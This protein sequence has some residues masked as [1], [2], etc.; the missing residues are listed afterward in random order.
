M[1]HFASSIY[2]E[3]SGYTRLISQPTLLKYTCSDNLHCA[4]FTTIY[5]MHISGEHLSGVSANNYIQDS[6][7][8]DIAANHFEHTYV[9]SICMQPQ[10]DMP[11]NPLVCYHKHDNSKK[12]AKEQWILE[13]ETLLSLYL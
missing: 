7:H 2:N 8:L 10:T 4:T 5:Y 11:I 13:I 1:Y 12:H 9:V 3:V 6:A